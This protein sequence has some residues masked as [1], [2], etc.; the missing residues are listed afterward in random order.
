M[1]DLGKLL[2]ITGLVLILVGGLLWKTGSLGPLG[3]LPGDISIQR[4]NFGFYFP[5]TT[6]ILISLILTLLMWLFRR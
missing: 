1:R 5:L 2:V 6:C 3:K 4:P